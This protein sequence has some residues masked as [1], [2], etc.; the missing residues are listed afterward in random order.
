MKNDLFSTPEN[1]SDRGKKNL[2]RAWH[3]GTREA[4]LLMGRFADV[5]LPKATDADLDQFEALLSETDPDIYDWI[6]GR[7]SLPDAVFRPVLE[8]MIAFYQVQS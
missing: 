3:R 4:D 7:L 8:Q 1:L 6:T 2:F 5:F